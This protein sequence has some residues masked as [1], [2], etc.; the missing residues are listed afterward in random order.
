MCSEISHLQRPSLLRLESLRSIANVAG[1]RMMWTKRWMTS[2]S[3]IER[4][5]II[6]SGATTCRLRITQK[7]DFL[8]RKDLFK[9]NREEIY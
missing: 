8:N 4:R 9:Q 1:K 6:L 7:R 3:L 2:T 5:L